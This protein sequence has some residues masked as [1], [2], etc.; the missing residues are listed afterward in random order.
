M[1]IAIP[2]N[3]FYAPLLTNTEKVAEKY[4]VKFFKVSEKQ[5]G[6]LLLANS[7][8]MSLLTPYGYGMAVAQADYRVVPGPVAILHSYTETASLYFKEGAGEIEKAASPTPDD[9]LMQAAMLILAE[10]Y[11]LHPTLERNPVAITEL[12]KSYDAAVAWGA[13]GNATVALD[14]SEDWFDTFEMPLPLAFWTYRLDD[15]EHPDENLKEIIAELADENLPAEQWI[16]EKLTTGAA[17]DARAGK[18]QWKWNEETEEAISA[19]LHLLYLHLKIK[20]I[21]AVKIFGRD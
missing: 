2:D 17:F 19:A 1:K 16:G 4:N 10:K 3:P 18:I 5:C 20:E 15:P 11:D 12:L 21:P 9:F 13:N 7:V 14:I 6:E 8:E